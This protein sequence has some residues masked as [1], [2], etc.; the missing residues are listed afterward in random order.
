MAQ[1]LQEV[2]QVLTHCSLATAALKRQ[3]TIELST[4]GS[5]LVALK[6]CKDLIVALCYKLQMFGVQ[7]KGSAYVFCD[8]QGVV[9]LGRCTHALHNDLSLYHPGKKDTDDVIAIV[10]RREAT[11]LAF[12]DLMRGVRCAGC[13]G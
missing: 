12:H 13:Q 10:F 3:N 9:Q 7:I 5:E 6:I 2:H 4:F 8:D 11:L 1:N